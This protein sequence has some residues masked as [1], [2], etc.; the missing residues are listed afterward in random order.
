MAHATAAFAVALFVLVWLHVRE[1]WTLPGGLA[2]G[3]AGA[4][5]VMVREQDVTF[6]A[7]PAVD[8]GACDVLKNPQQCGCGR[9]LRATAAAA[10]ACG[11]SFLP[12]AVAYLALNGRVGPSRLVS[13]KMNWLTPHAWSILA[14]PEHGFFL[15]TP[16]ALVALAGLAVMASGSG[17]RNPGTHDSP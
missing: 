8:S 12:Q 4:L 1:R 13:R 14:S 11:V 17:A 15:W 5:M 3:A 2:L 6:F 10:L 9:A 7:A 16:L